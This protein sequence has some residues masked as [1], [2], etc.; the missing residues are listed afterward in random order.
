MAK[1]IS[2][3]T[4]DVSGDTTKLQKSLNQLQAPINKINTELKNV[5]KAMQLNPTSIT[6]WSQKQEIL[7]RNISLTKEKLDALKEAQRGLGAYSNLT[8]QQKENYNRLSLEIAKSEDALKKMIKQF[9]IL[10]GLSLEN[11]E[12]GL[13][14][15]GEI[16]VEVSK[17]L[18]EISSAVAGA[19]ASVV[20]LGV[21]SYAE[22]EKAQ[23]GAK[24]LF[25][26]SFETVKKNAA[27]AYK[28]LGL[29]AT[30]Y[31]DQVNQ[32]AVGLKEALGGDSEAAAQLSN[33]IL[34][35]QADIV[36]AT[37]A[38][39]DAVQNAFAAVMRNN[40]TMI[41]NLRLGIKGSKEGMQEAIDKV[42]EWNASMGNATNYQIGNLA[43][44]EKALVDYTKMVKIAGTAQEQMS[45]TISGSIT[46]LK[47]AFDNFLNGSGS[48]EALAE[49]VLN[50]LKNIAE[51]IR[52]LAP[53]ILSG[54]VALIKDLIPQVV[55]MLFELLPQL[56]D[57]VSQLID[58]LLNLLTNNT[59]SIQQAITE[60]INKV[61]L[62]IT[63][64]LPKILQIV[65][66][67]ALMLAKAITESLP[68]IIPAIIQCIIEIANILLDNIDI[69]IM[70]IVDIV[71]ALVDAIDKEMP[72][73]IDKMPELIEKLALALIKLIPVL[74]EAVV[75]IIGAILNLLI[76]NFSRVFDLGKDLGKELGKG[77]KDAIPQIIEKVKEVIGKIAEKLGELPSKAFQ[78]GEDMIQ[79]LI[80]GIKNMIGGVG[81]AVKGIA[82]SIASF[83][84]FSRPDEGPLAEYET[85]MPDFINGLAKSMR[86]SSGILEDATLDLADDM[87]SSLLKNTSMALRGLNAGI[88][89]SLNPTINPTYSY[90]LNYQLMSSAMKEA[91]E[92]VGVYL[93]DRKL[94]QFIDKKVS[95]EVYS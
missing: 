35:A 73:I 63:D 94:G 36:A 86:N 68:T 50:T 48:P 49:T 46:Q 10:P 40:F 15:V 59:D 12:K 44:M 53:S 5:E 28:S 87:S 61:V 80:D 54:I 52:T 25:E 75:K 93:D 55:K 92:E 90:D 70:A 72:N 32:Y 6:L 37:G 47:A 2:G 4:I 9:Q 88:Q 23:K 8:E 60:L 74:L 81:E 39:T 11:L 91:L 42:N 7:S 30:Q 26:E 27:E 29:S 17:K 45:S 24:R 67:L 34:V 43:D 62:F 13:K 84:H 14:K 66:Q 41:D 21:K 19:L 77:L 89:A 95:E 38:S 57:S 1:K 18:V 83:L 82:D 76:N 78:W 31:Y 64:N 16:A 3:I 71:V 56:L 51:A 33:D 22:L 20:G 79:G 65:I 69:L 58:E 85:W